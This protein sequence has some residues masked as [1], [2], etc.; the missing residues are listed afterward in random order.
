M[1]EYKSPNDT[2]YDRYRLISECRCKRYPLYDL[3]PA[4]RIESEERDD[5]TVKQAELEA[6]E[7]LSCG[8]LTA[9]TAGGIDHEHYM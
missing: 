1:E 4:D 9:D 5:R 2:P 8:H 3:L 6:Q 7:A